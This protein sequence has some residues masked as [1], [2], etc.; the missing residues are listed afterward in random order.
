MDTKINK[1]KAAEETRRSRGAEGWPQM[2]STLTQEEHSAVTQNTG[3]SAPWRRDNPH[4]RTCLPVGL[5]SYRTSWEEVLPKCQPEPGLVP[6]KSVS[7]GKERSGEVYA[8]IK[9]LRRHMV[10]CKV[11]GKKQLKRHIRIKGKS[12]CGLDSGWIR[13]TQESIVNS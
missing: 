2:T 9:R 13:Y 10:E 4:P 8:W 5:G 12:E 7:L 11:F 1:L 3:D 6:Q